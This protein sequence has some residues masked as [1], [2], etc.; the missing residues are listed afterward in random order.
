[1]IF[2]NLKHYLSFIFFAPGLIFAQETKEID[3]SGLKPPTSPGFTILDIAPNSI[4]HPKTI[5][6][7]TIST[8]NLF[9]R[10]FEIPKNFA[11]ELSP[12]WM[13][14]NTF[15]QITGLKKKGDR[16]K[17]NIFSDI[18]FS[19]ISI[20]SVYNDT[21]NTTM[22]ASN[23]NHIGYGFKVNLI[24]VF[25]RPRISAIENYINLIHKE[26]TGVLDEVD[27]NELPAGVANEIRNGTKDAWK[28]VIALRSI[29][30]LFQLQIAGASA[31][32]FP[33]NKGGKFHRG[34]GWLTAGMSFPLLKCKDEHY[35]KKLLNNS[36]YFNLVLLGRFMTSSFDSI[37]L[38]HRQS[39]LDI[40]GRV[41]LEL[42]RLL[43]GIEYISR[44]G[45]NDFVSTHR[46]AGMIEYRMFNNVFVVGSFGRNFGEYN[47]IISGL[48][49]N[50]GFG[51]QSI[52]KPLNFN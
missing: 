11:F 31:T 46:F 4:E 17:Q 5:K 52:Y 51:K 6:E 20:A 47:N 36:K 49:L 13:L 44:S 7:F 15:S 16:L 48:G 34:G 42:N 45:N 3:L 40:G 41:E 33:E 37:Y 50:W 24:K 39:L 30:P 12:G 18:R 14:N 9:N 22:L 26:T 1:M 28:K 19:S 2:Q 35:S 27:P 10:G 8:A 25:N 29:R 23:T 32:A 43:I 21:S 38:E